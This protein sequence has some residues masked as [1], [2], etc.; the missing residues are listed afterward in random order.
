MKTVE[1]WLLLAMLL[2]A[3]AVGFIV[4][5]PPISMAF[6]PAASDAFVISDADPTK[7]RAGETITYRGRFQR[8]RSCQ[9]TVDWKWQS[10]LTGDI[11]D[12]RLNRVINTGPPASR[13]VDRR[14][15]VTVPNLRPGNY[16]FWVNLT[17]TC[18]AFR[19]RRFVLWGRQAISSRQA[20]IKFEI[21]P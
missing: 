1:H 19:F 11:S 18:E 5:W 14:Y 20:A 21:L 3:G 16:L 12:V 7:A 10:R 13:Y 9:L 17:Y 15:S 2:F 8:Y 4:L 6:R